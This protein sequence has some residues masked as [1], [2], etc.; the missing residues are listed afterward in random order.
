MLNKNTL[1]VMS[2]T[3]LMSGVLGFVLM[4]YY[5]NTNLKGIAQAPYINLNILKEIPCNTCVYIDK[6]PKV[7]KQGSVILNASVYNKGK[8]LKK[9]EVISGREYTQNLNRNVSGNKSPSPNGIYAIE[10]LTRGYSSETGGV[11]IPYTP[12]FNTG[13]SNL[14]FHIDPSWGLKNRENGTEGCI[15][16]K[17]LEEFNDFNNL[18]IYNKIDQLIINF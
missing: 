5:I 1:I 9:F 18:I 3:S 15:G 16:F 4:S 13:R 7:N 14:G 2:I 10:K 17:N 12:L 6:S 11:F 8:Y